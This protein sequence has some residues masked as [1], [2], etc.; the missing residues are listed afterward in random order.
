MNKL[1]I[2][3]II[4]GLIGC[5]PQ[6]VGPVGPPGPQGL[7]GQPGQNGEDGKDGAPGVQG[8]MGATGPKGDQ[9]VAGAVGPTGANG[10]DASGVTVVQLC[11]GTTT[12][13]NVFTEVAFCIHNKLYAVYSL[14]SGF[15]T[16]IVPG[17]YQSNA[18]GSSCT[19]TV[20]P[21]CVV[22]H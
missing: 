11:P 3:A 18:V 6:L 21:N 19:F 14:N 13:P 10:V 17:T 12:Y 5:G 16:E 2:A 7:T 22:T 8:A 9:G 15:E 4:V 20:Q 1:I